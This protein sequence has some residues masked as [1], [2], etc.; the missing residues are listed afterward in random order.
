MEGALAIIL[1]FG[2]GLLFALSLSPVGRALAD[3]IRHGPSGQAGS[4]PELLAEVQQLR[5]DVADL[6]ERVDFSER[7]LSQ[8][9]EP[10]KLS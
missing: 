7:L 3:R 2:G 5:Q 4:D 1:I 6:H 10:E 8:H 9:R